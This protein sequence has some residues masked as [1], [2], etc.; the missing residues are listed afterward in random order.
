MTYL[1]P[2]SD[3]GLVDEKLIYE[4]E[5]KYSIKLPNSYI[6]LLSKFNAIRPIKEFFK[7][8]YF[9]KSIKTRDICFYG[10]GY[11]KIDINTL[12]DLVRFQNSI[13][14]TESISHSQPDECGHD[15]IIAFAQSSEG[16]YV[17]FDYRH[18]PKTNNPKI[19]LMFHD[20]YGDDN[21]MLLCP[22]ADSFEEFV[23]ML[24]ADKDE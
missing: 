1:E 13:L 2:Y 6:E 21:K 23:G 10:Y 17:C 12:E 24:Y 11:K 16:D 18:D 7:F 15:N 22:L 9:G 14:E 5:R 8:S 19:V 3:Y 4:F 20:E